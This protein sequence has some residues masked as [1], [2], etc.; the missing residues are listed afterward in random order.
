LIDDEISIGNYVLTGGELPSMVITDAIVRLIPGVLEKEATE[1]ESYSED[2]LLDF[3]QYT[4]P[5]NYKGWKVPEVLLSGNH[6]EIDKWRIKQAKA[7][8]KIKR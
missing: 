8:S 7:N 6:A 5:S 1:K 4:R 3:P 2:N